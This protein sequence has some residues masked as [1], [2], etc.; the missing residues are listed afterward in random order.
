MELLQIF[1][2]LNA[3]L[4]AI[5]GGFLLA[6]FYFIVSKQVHRH[7]TCML[8]ASSVSALFLISYISYHIIRSYFY[9]IGPTRFTGGGLA[10]PIY[11]TRLT[12]HTILAAVIA[13]FI[14]LTL[15]RALKSRFAE[16]KKIARLVYPVWLYV[17]VTG[18]I[19]YLMLYH[20]YPNR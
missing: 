11:F 12:S 14:M 1:P 8:A 2:H 20:F 7:R 19:V 17:S 9:G 13:P 3:L 15:W 5:S 6:G 4:N 18:V 10:R 16:H